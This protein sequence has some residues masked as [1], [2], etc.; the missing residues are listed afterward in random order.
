MRGIYGTVVW[1]YEEKQ[2]VLVRFSGSQQMYFP[3]DELRRWAD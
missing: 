3:P 2:Q 1:F